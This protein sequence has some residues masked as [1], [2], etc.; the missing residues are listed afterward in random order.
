MD[1]RTKTD[2]PRKVKEVESFW[3]P[4]SDGD[5]CQVRLV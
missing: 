1:I 2:F 5:T 4:M 3:I